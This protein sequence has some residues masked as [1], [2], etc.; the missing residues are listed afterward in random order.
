MHCRWP[1]KERAVLW[2]TQILLPMT[3]MIPF[4]LSTC[5]F[6][7]CRQTFKKKKCLFTI[8]CRN[9]ITICIRW[10]FPDCFNSWYPCN[11]VD[12]VAKSHDASLATFMTGLITISAVNLLL[13]HHATTCWLTI[14]KLCELVIFE[15][16]LWIAANNSWSSKYSLYF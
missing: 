14:E 6:I 9:Y 5:Q 10:Q 15:T 7:Y 2:I 12:R 8:L 11:R 16:L 3:S 1:A 4:V 13:W